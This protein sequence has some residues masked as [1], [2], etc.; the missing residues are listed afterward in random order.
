MK[1]QAKEKN[2]SLDCDRP[3]AEGKGEIRESHARACCCEQ[4]NGD[5]IKCMRNVKR[6]DLL[7][8]MRHRKE[9]E[10]GFRLTDSAVQA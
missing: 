4:A 9:N 1:R 5:P 8:R 2:Y 3:E 10:F 7:G 6:K